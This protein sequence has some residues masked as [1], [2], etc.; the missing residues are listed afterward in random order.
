MSDTPTRDES[1]AK[2]RELIADARVAMLTT[3]DTDGAPWSRPMGL[4]KPGDFDGTLYFYTQADT[5]KVAHIKRT[6]KVS[7]S[8][9]QPGDQEYV[10][11]TGTAAVTND[12]EKIRDLWTLP[13]RAWYPDGPDDPNLR[14][15]EVEV[16]RAEYWDSPASM[17]AYAFGLA[18]A[19]ATGEPADDLGENA[20]VSL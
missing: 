12:R 13:V 20:K 15:I 7:V 9:V 5:D 18:K 14:L 3:I 19:I 17:V 8:V 1:V 4:Q 11:L 16:D 2:L 10:T 6:P